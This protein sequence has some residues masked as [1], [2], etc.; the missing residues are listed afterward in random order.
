MKSILFYVSLSLPFYW[1]LHSQT[2]DQFEEPPCNFSTLAGEHDAKTCWIRD[3]LKNF[4]QRVERATT[5]GKLFGAINAW[6]FF[7]P[8]KTGKTAMAQAIAQESGAKLFYHEEKDIYVDYSQPD[9]TWYASLL[10]VKEAYTQ[11]EQYIAETHK[12]AVIVFDDI[13][14][15][16][17][18]AIG[19]IRSYIDD[20]WRNPLIMTIVIAH[21]AVSIDLPLYTRC[22]VIE[23]P[24]PSSKNRKA[25]LKNE[26]VKHHEELSTSALSI[27][28]T[29]TFYASPEDIKNLGINISH[30][31]KNGSW[32]ACPRGYVKTFKESAIMQQNFARS[33]A[34]LTATAFLLYLGIRRGN[35]SQ[36]YYQTQGD[37]SPCKK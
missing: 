19:A 5:E 17:I 14:R 2:F 6:I 27:L 30:Y 18:D 20:H 33:A 26:L 29:L 37:H 36:R 15:Y 8:H 12:P 1:S 11:A 3:A 32:F 7:G 34:A 23:F 9:V 10:K 13:D 21:D 16:T 22:S 4:E 28:N 25:I 35:I 31:R 24:R